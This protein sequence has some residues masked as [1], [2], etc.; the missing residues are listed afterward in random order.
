MAD[1]YSSAFYDGPLHAP[2]SQW[3]NVYHVDIYV[4]VSSPLSPLGF[5][6]DGRFG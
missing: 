3:E 5:A 1:T 6:C 4:Q 2:T